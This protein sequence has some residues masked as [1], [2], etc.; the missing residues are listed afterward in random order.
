MFD[1][2]TGTILESPDVSAVKT[3]RE[4][5]RIFKKLDLG[6]D[7]EEILDRKA[8]S[9]FFSND[10][11]CSREW[12]LTEQQL[13][14]LKTVCKY[15]LPNLDNHQD[16]ELHYKH[17]PGS[18]FEQS[19]MNQKWSIVMSQMGHLE[20]RGFDVFLHTVTSSTKTA[21]DVPTS[22]T[23]KLV[24]VPKHSRARRTITV[25]PCVRQFV[26]QGYNTLLRREIER[27]RIL[28][29]CLALTDQ[30]LNQKLAID[31]SST[32]YW[33]TLD[34]KSASDLMSLRHVELVFGNR[35]RFLSG[36]LECRSPFVLNGETPYLLRKYAGMG[37]ATTFPVQSVVFAVIAISA[38][39][40]GTKV[41]TYR[42]VA[43]A[44]RMVRVYGDDI[45]VPSDHAPKV[46]DWI[47]NIGLLVNV[48]KSFSTGNFRESCGVDAFRGF[49]VTPCYVRHHPINIGRRNPKVIAHYVAQANK[50]YM[51]GYYEAADV[52][53]KW[54]EDALKTRLPLVRRHSS[55]LGLHT[56]LDAYESHSWDKYLHR[57]QLKAYCISPVVRKDVISGYAALM[58]FFLT[59]RKDFLE[60]E[61]D[62]IRTPVRFKTRI[63]RRWVASA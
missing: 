47:N 63:T 24:S 18:V 44:A 28:R 59:P 26:Q 54:V 6:S 19:T 5:T 9:E 52:C 62:N 30:S 13:F 41:P 12:K 15:I 10:E 36:I 33:A 1:I 29:Q 20:S 50:F 56:R 14:V 7:G 4:I 53:V 55:A 2:I 58:K 45:I 34:L 60:K 37:N 17:G 51:L 31:G 35:P 46:I 3:L 23:A 57:P 43:R 11:L 21:V 27:D 8:K 22:S 32:G 16:E 49:D 61:D 42:N 25:E 39:I 38:L 48:D 40:C